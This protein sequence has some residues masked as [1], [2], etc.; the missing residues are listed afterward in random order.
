MKRFFSQ[1]CLFLHHSNNKVQP[2]SKQCCCISS[3][4][5]LNPILQ[6]T[7]TRGSS[8]PLKYPF[9]KHKSNSNSIES[10][11]ERK[12]SSHTKRP[13]TLCS[14]CLSARLVDRRMQEEEQPLGHPRVTAVSVDVSGLACATVSHLWLN[15]V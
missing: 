9:S 8:S 7:L 15:T 6:G 3:D 2:R 5:S 12:K 10:S 1:W 13:Y 14:F 4:P 11:T